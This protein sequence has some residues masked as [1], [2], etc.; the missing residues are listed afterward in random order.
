MFRSDHVVVSLRMR[1]WW[2]SR[3]GNTHRAAL[4]R[5]PIRDRSPL[6][7]DEGAVPRPPAVRR[8]DAQPFAVIARIKAGLGEGAAVDIIPVSRAAH[9]HPSIMTAGMQPG[10]AADSSVPP[11]DRVSAA[12]GCR[13]LAIRADVPDQPATCASRVGVDATSPPSGVP[14]SRRPRR[15]R[16]SIRS[17]TYPRWF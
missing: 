17:S 12:R 2:R 11:S 15:W 4:E 10:I 8:A 3:G 5:L 6:C 9:R 1:S 7:G 13:S 16:P 14:V